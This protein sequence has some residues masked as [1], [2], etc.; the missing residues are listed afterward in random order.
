MKLNILPKF[1]IKL[2]VNQGNW[3]KIYKL[4]GSIKGI[5]KEKLSERYHSQGSQGLRVVKVV[6]LKSSGI[7]KNMNPIIYTYIMT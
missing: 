4:Q 1:I 7:R 3:I 6:I 2:W 5:K